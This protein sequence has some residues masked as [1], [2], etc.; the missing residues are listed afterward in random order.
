ME[1]TKN[2]I[3]YILYARKSSESEDRQVLSIDSQVDELKE[4]AKRNGI[5]IADIKTEAH[6][7]KAPGRPVLNQLL[8]DIETNKAQGIIVWNP[9]R[10]SRNSVDIGKIIYLFDLKKLIEVVTP[11]QIFRNT[12]NDKFLL[13]LLCG[14][15]KLENDNKSINVKRGLKAKAE[16][17]IYPAPAPLGY[18]ND[19]YAE[20]GNKTI[21]SDPERFE[22]VRKIFELMLSGNYT[23]PQILKIANN[24][25][26]FRTPQGNKLCR[27]SIYYI[28]TRPFYYGFFEYPIGSNN[29]YKGI[30]KPMI[31]EEEYDRIQILLGRK[32]KPRSKNHIFAF[33]G[34]IK[35][36]ECGAMITA[37]EKIKRCKNG[38]IH[39]YIYYH[40][41]KHKNQNCVQKCIEVKELER[42]IIEVLGNIKILPEFHNWAF[43]WLKKENEKE[44]ES[45]N[46][47]LSS[48]QRSY[49]ML[50]KKIDAI[51]DMRAGGEITEEEFTRKKQELEKRKIHIKELL[52]DTDG[53][54][55][56]WL[57]KAEEIF[58]FAETA[59]K[60]FETGTIE[61]KRQILN[62]LG[63]N[64]FLKDKILSI[65]IEKPLILIEK[66]AKEVKIIHNRLEPLK[67]G[68]NEHKMEL[69]YSQCPSLLRD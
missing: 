35:C 45:R 6:S 50:V 11:S 40:C 57:D 58:S 62:N 9:D 3:K 41:T 54:V 42:Q 32:G 29:W 46:S 21:V 22:L 31:T 52:E 20:R 37:E 25:W 61:D 16:R 4:L 28:L 67:S 68:Q 56:N 65:S 30:H 14:Q 53:R 5:K 49:N 1:N 34:M 55:K 63:S 51:I 38:N 36:G 24:D 10:L 43:K 33:T 64:L 23:P 12:P 27:S 13:G 44:A 8:E 2:K 19:R 59:K 17:G 47:I 60:K 66:A 7:A 18:L 26:D 39:H 69:L 48:Q 15:A